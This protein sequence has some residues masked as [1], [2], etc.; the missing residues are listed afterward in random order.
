MRCRRILIGFLSAITLSIATAA[1]AQLGQEPGP[2]PRIWVGGGGGY[3]YFRR[4]P[5][6]WATRENF[7]GSFNFCRAY[8]SANRRE[9]GGS[10]WDTA[11]FRRAAMRS[12]ST[13]FC[14]H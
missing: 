9:A 6:K 3:G 10:G 11:G 4:T 12:A 1:L 8:F 2:R 14:T 7:D 13:S 5:P